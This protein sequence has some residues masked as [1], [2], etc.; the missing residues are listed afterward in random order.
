MSANVTLVTMALLQLTMALSQVSKREVRSTGR[1][2]WRW[3]H[4]GWRGRRKKVDW[5]GKYQ[6]PS[7]DCCLTYWS[8]C[9]RFKLDI[10]SDYWYLW[11]WHWL[12]HLIRLIQLA[13]EPW[14][15]VEMAFSSKNGH[16]W[17]NFRYELNKE[18]GFSTFWK[19]LQIFIKINTLKTQMVWTWRK[20]LKLTNKLL[21][22]ISIIKK[23]KINIFLVPSKTPIPYIIR[24]INQIL[25]DAIST[26]NMNYF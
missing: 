20:G 16:K 6:P 21:N 26:D 9:G 18:F 8:R 22:S 1:L 7:A 10:C 19:K 4:S 14:P 11:T 5:A 2:L 23:L 13:F 15:E 3:R 25:K 24:G 17:Q 12:K